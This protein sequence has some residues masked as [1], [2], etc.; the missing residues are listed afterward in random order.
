MTN[1]V[2]NKI[3]HQTQSGALGIMPGTLP[4]QGSKLMVE[5]SD[6]A[7]ELLKVSQDPASDLAAD[8]A[9]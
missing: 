5:L 1:N 9:R 7:K 4:Q 2:R 8:V 6:E 3:P